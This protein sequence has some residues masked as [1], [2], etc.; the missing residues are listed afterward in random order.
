VLQP[1][2]VRAA[3]GGFELIAGERRWRAAQ[4]AGLLKIPAVVRDADD[5]QLLELALVENLQRADLDPIEESKAYQ[6]LID[7]LGLTQQEVAERVGKP[8]ATVA[9]S[10]RLLNLPVE[11]QARIQDGELS[12][13]HAKALAALTETKT[14]IE[15]ARRIVEQ[16]LTV[17]AVEALVRRPVSRARA[18]KTAAAETRDPNVV[19]AEQ[20]LQKT[21]GTKVRIVQKASGSGRVEIEF[22]SDEELERLYE[23]LEGRHSR[24]HA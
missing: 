21:L 24:R 3:E 23:M 16:G 22:Y 19:A 13:G 7:E 10:L 12:A 9:N 20:Q 8:R 11:V 15:L 2:I 6:T 4:M 18:S 14:Q 1:V 5:E 17:R